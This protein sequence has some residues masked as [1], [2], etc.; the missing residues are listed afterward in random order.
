MTWFISKAL[1]DHCASLPCSQ[2]QAAAFSAAGCSDGNA[3]VPSNSTSMPATFLSHVKTMAHSRRFP[4]GMTFAHLTADHGAALLMSFRV[5]SLARIYQE[6]SRAPNGSMAMPRDYGASTSGSFAKYCPHTHSLRMH[7]LSL[8][9]DST[10]FCATLPRAGTMRNGALWE[11]QTSGRRTTD[12]DAGFS[13][14]LPTPLARDCKDGPQPVY[15]NGRRQFDTLGRAIGGKPNPMF[16]EWLMGWP[17][18]HTDL[19]PL[20]TDRFRQWLR[21]HG[22]LCNEDNETARAA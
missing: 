14:L 10:A 5:D 1:H 21:L 12:N 7:Q 3:S 19:Q 4:Y 11:H 13:Q 9:E 16:S 6:S 8:I 17:L 2:A 18:N 22:V 15:R 20:E